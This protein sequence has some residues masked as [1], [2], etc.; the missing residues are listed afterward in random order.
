MWGKTLKIINVG[1]GERSYPI[2]IGRGIFDALGDA[3]Q[4]VAFPKKVAI[5]TN[6][7]VGPI[8]GARIREVLA[9]SGFS[10]EEITIPD[11]EEYKNL[12]TLNQVFDAL[13]RRGYD[14]FCGIIALGGGVVGDLAGFAAATYLRGVPFAQ[15]PTTLLSQVDSS[16][17][18]KTAVN[19]RLGKNLIGAFYQ[20]C[21]VHIDVATLDTL[22]E[23]EFAAGLAEVVKYGVIRDAAFFAWLENSRNELLAH[24]P[25]ALV[26]AVAISCQTKAN[27]VEVDEKEGGVRAILNFGHTLGHAAEVLAGYGTIRHGEAVAIGM[28]A[29]AAIARQQG[30]CTGEDLQRIEALLVSFGLPVRLPDFAANDYLAA[31]TRDKKVKEGVLRLVLNRAI[32]DCLIESVSSV[33][34]IIV[35]IIEQ[36]RKRAEK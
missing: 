15:V 29:A 30:L 18:G 32:G 26:E 35:P 3:L 16:V 27:I 1:L 2:W 31:L 20:P 21:H 11:G 9:R 33:E 12:D 17:G 13:I 23:R 4:Q 6:E 8:Y 14:R 22:P 5:V 10:A 7:T 24:S 28:V 34:K 36:Y 25:A 19:H